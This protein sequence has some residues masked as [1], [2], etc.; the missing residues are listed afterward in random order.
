[1][2]IQFNPFLL[3]D[4][5]NAGLVLLYNQ[6]SLC[7]FHLAKKEPLIEVG[8]FGGGPRNY[9]NKK[10][11]ALTCGIREALEELYQIHNGHIDYNY[12]DLIVSVKRNI[13]KNRTP[14]IHLT[15]DDPNHLPYQ[16]T[17]LKDKQVNSFLRLISNKIEYT[18]TIVYERIPSNLDDIILNRRYHE[19]AEAKAVGLLPTNLTRENNNEI[20]LNEKKQISKEEFLESKGIFYN[21]IFHHEDT[22]TLHYDLYSDNKQFSEELSNKTNEDKAY[23]CLLNKFLGIE[24]V[25]EIIL[26]LRQKASKYYSCTGNRY[27]IEYSFR[28]L[29]DIFNILREGVIESRL[30]D[31]NRYPRTIEEIFSKRVYKIENIFEDCIYLVPSITNKNFEKFHGIKRNFVIKEE[32]YEDSDELK[33]HFFR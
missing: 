7:S 11:P 27:Y 12:S 21:V 19:R 30:Y 1:M 33:A 3:K 22:I 14:Y 26:L 13:I 17:I 9:K 29:F 10:E 15:Y 5:C 4:T 20:F 32:L 28:D 16:G 8:G 2:P 23:E 31:K 6:Y 18:D 24:K 25:E